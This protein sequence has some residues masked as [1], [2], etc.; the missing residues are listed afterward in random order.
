MRPSSP[1]PLNEGDALLTGR[2]ELCTLRASQLGEMRV[3]YFQICP[4]LLTGVLSPVERQHLDKVTRHSREPLKVFPSGHPIAQ[5]L[6]T[7]SSQARTGDNLILRCL[8]LQIAAP[9]LTEELPRL[10]TRPNNGLNAAERFARLIT[11]IPEARIHDYS[12]AELAQLCGCGTRHFARLYKSHFGHSFVSK[13]NE[14]KLE[15]ARQL[16][17]ETDDKIIDV[18]LESGFHHIG[19]FTTMFRQRYR[20]T[21]SDWRRRK[22][23]AADK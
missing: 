17:E 21:P 11:E 1:Q 13:K 3:E 7:L 4:E 8:M 12:P 6:A 14:L 10:E 15:K 19:L 18:A 2:A 16:L 23:L 22:R 5:Q 20:R 9:I